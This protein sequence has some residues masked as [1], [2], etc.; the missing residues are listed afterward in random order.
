MDHD[1]KKLAKDNELLHRQIHHLTSQIFHMINMN[2]GYMR[3]ISELERVVDDKMFLAEHLPSEESMDVPMDLSPSIR[4]KLIQLEQVKAILHRRND[5]VAELERQ[6]DLY[7]S[8]NERQE[9]AIKNLKFNNEERT[10]QVKQLD[11][12]TRLLTDQVR[13]LTGV[14]ERWWGNPFYKMAVR[15]KGLLTGGKR[16]EP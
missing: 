10:A 7:K 12:E 16:R 6:L 4:R 9:D 5:L 13:L 3:R 2:M 15:A 11:E 1:G 14:V 8:N